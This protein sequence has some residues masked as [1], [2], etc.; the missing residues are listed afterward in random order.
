MRWLGITANIQEQN[1]LMNER[2]VK[3]QSKLKDEGFRTYIMKGQG[4]AALYVSDLSSFRQS[5][6]IDRYLDDRYE[7]VIG[8]VMEKN[9]WI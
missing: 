9:K 7:E 2:C 8:F 3:L 6:D 1:K 4:N 5:G